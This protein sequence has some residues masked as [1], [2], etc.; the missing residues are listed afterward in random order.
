[1]PNFFY[2]TPWSAILGTW[3]LYYFQLFE[4]ILLKEFKFFLVVVL[5]YQKILQK[6]LFA[7]AEKTEPLEGYRADQCGI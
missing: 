3:G 7:I 1:M 5:L 6:Q 4:D 2:M